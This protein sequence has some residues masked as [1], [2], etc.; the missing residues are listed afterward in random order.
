MYTSGTRVPC[1]R[2][3]LCSSYKGALQ[4]V[5]P[6]LLYKCSFP[7]VVSRSFLDS[8]KCAHCRIATLKSW[9]FRTRLFCKR[10]PH[11]HFTRCCQ[12]RS[13]RG[14]FH[15]IVC[16]ALLYGI[17]VHFSDSNSCLPSTATVSFKL[18]RLLVEVFCRNMPY[19][20]KCVRAMTK[21]GVNKSCARLS[22][23]VSRL[24]SPTA[25]CRRFWRTLLS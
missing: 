4:D 22:K 18:A 1:K 23:T 24:C 8:T 3:W 21:I 12:G 17:F 13:E 15:K 25:F 7:K 19:K 6:G 9:R 2:T 14:V 10:V 5:P 16:T 20:M 11:E